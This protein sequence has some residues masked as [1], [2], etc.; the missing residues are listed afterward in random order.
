MIGQYPPEAE[1]DLS[2]A[3]TDLERHTLRWLHDVFNRKMLG[4][5]PASTR[6]RR[7]TTAP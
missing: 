3:A 1:P 7:S 6:R 5:I 2:I 4:Q